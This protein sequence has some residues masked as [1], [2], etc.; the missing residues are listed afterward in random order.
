M[1]SRRARDSDRPAAAH[2]LREVC[3]TVLVTAAFTL[4][5]YSLLLASVNKGKVL[6]LAGAG[7]ERTATAAEA[8]QIALA[9]GTLA[10]HDLVFVVLDTSDAGPE[11]TALNAAT[12][13]ASALT[14]GGTDA[15]VR[16]LGPWDSDFGAIVTQ[17][18][19]RRFPAVLA[20]KKAGG[21]VLVKDEID[22]EILLSVHRRFW[23]RASSCNDAVSDIY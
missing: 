14:D 21:I 18:G 15:A 16:I 9:L 2:A 6:P 4:G 8:E 20:V 11:P 7:L 5:F 13:A 10:R 22:E 23:V 17:N 3:F 12:R 1:E 19:V